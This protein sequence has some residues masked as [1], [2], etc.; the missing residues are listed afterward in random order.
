[1]RERLRWDC[2]SGAAQRER[3]AGDGRRVYCC[4][5]VIVRKL[6]SPGTSRKAAA[7]R[8]RALALAEPGCRHF[9]LLS[10]PLDLDNSQRSSMKEAEAE[11]PESVL[12]VE[13]RRLLEAISSSAMD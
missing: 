1:M 10:G 4:A 6:Q 8:A 11:V 5:L 7:D 9:C 2:L 3:N 13:L 12:A